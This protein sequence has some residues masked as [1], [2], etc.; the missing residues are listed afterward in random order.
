VDIG[1]GPGRLTLQISRRFPGLKVIALDNN[2]DMLA[3][4]GRRLSGRDISLV[5]ASVQTMPFD[6]SSLD[7][8]VSTGSLHHWPE[9]DRAL[10]EIYRVLK[11][12]GQLMIMDLRRD[13]RCYLSPLALLFH[14]IVPAAIKRTNGALGSLY[15]SYTPQEA[16]ALSGAA[17]FRQWRVKPGLVW[18]FIQ[19]RK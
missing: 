14:L 19:A 17:S 10:R 15:A 11:P 9:A 1:C 7:F 2:R 4:A 18:F 5:Q 13:I 12:G 6:D 8:V 3:L 16:R